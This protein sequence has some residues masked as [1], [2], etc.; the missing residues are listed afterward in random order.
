MKLTTKS[1]YCLLA[2]IY[3]A[4]NE[5][6]GYVRSKDICEFYNI[7]RKYVESLL[8]LLKTNGIIKA[9]TGKGGGFKLARKSNEISLAEIIRTMDGA[10][11]PVLSVSKFFHEDTPLMKEPTLLC[12]F[13]EIRD[14]IS[15]RLE[16][17]FL[18]SFL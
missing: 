11:A 1:E 13:G 4:R 12:V 14:Y 15:N 7:S 10:L 9:K 2:L 16:N 5:N 6:M 17:T 3:I 8:S 18:S